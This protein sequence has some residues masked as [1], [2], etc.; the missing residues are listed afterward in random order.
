MRI[1]MIVEYDGTG[2]CGWQRQKSDVSVQGC[3][4]KALLKLTQETVD[5]QASGRTDAGVH[6]LGQVAHFDTQCAIPAEKYA[7]ALNCL[8]PHDIRIKKTFEASEE[9]HARFHAKKKR[10]RYVI[11]NARH[12]S[13]IER[14]HC[15]HVPVPLD[16]E[17]M[18]QAAQYIKGTHDFIAL[19]N[20]KIFVTNTVR[21]IYEITV[22]KEGDKVLIELVGNGFLYN[23]VR[24]IAGTLIKIGRGKAEPAI[25]RRIVEDKDRKLI[26][27]TA[28]PQGLFLVD[29]EYE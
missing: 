23:M 8:L 19:C 27:M 3:I 21:T 1:V 9:F 29:V 16:I 20:T 14:N 6:A 12:A 11:L 15:M 24:I 28:Q 7:F 5:L 13:A 25:M 26:G 17:K 2:Y 10:Y 22:Q 4:E 18:R